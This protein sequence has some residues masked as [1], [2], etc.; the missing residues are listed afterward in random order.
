[1]ELVGDRAFAVD[2]ALIFYFDLCCFD[3]FLA[4]FDL[5]FVVDEFGEFG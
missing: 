1:M 4:S 2:V 3:D 5:G